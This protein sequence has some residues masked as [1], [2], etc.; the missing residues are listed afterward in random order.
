MQ[1][2]TE[3]GMEVQFDIDSNGILNIEAVETVTGRKVRLVIT[4]D[5]VRER[6]PYSCVNHS[7]PLGCVLNGSSPLPVGRRT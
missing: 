7:S 6:T 4:N 2:G 5:K 1:A 3:V